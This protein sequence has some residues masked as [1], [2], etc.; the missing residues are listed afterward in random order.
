M[1]WLAHK[2][3]LNQILKKRLHLLRP[4]SWRWVIV[5]FF[6]FCLY[7]SPLL[8]KSGRS[9]C[10]ILLEHWQIYLISFCSTS[11]S[12]NSCQVKDPAL[13]SSQTTVTS[14]SVSSYQF[15][16]KHVCFVFCKCLREIF[17]KPHWPS[18][19]NCKSIQHARIRQFMVTLDGITIYCFWSHLFSNWLSKKVKDLPL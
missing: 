8:E 5:A 16:Q 11:Q 7:T 19:P 6:L 4:S 13:A 14:S 2:R 9:H 1:F 12:Y 18:I 10:L 17:N 15:C 3:T